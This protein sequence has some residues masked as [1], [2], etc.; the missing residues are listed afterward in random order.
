MTADKELWDLYTKYREPAGRVHE[1]G[2]ITEEELFH[3]TVHGWI[4]NPRGEYL[5]S[6]RAGDRPIYPLLWECPG[7]S[8]LA[9]ETSLRGAVREV[10]EEVGIDLRPEDG[11]L[12]FTKIRG[13]MDGIHYHDIKDIW[14]FEYDGEARLSEAE[15][16]EVSQCRFMAPDEIERLID[17]GK[18]VPVLQ[19]FPYMLAAGLPDDSTG[20]GAGGKKKPDYRAIIGK[21]V[22]V[23][24]DRP[25]N[26]SHPKHPDLVY[27][28]NY[29]YVEG[30][31]GGDD[32]EQDVYVLG[33]SRPLM[34]FSGR[35]T[36]VYRR[37]DDKEDKWIAVPDGLELADNRILGDIYFQEQFFSGKLYR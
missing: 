15:T 7:G 8:V 3:I 22:S 27:P 31:Q 16:A 29:G 21:P 24:I 1:R 25:M 20:G 17:A 14:L 13:V 30:V 6:Q 12:L 18:C 34:R 36:A 4:R 9:G 2:Q 10:K 23:T 5:M 19:Y 32:E 26:S 35:V 11:K 28:V 33:V 37:F